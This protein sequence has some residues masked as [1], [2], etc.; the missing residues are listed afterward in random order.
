[1]KKQIIA[2]LLSLCMVLSL[3]PAVAFAG[4]TAPVLKGTPLTQEL[5]AKSELKQCRYANRILK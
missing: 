1:M 5:L 4:E 2:I 3:T